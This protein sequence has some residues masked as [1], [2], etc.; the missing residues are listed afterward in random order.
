M[1]AWKSLFIFL[2]STVK[3]SYYWSCC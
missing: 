3:T 2:I 1:N